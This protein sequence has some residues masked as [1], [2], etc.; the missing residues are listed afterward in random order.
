VAAMA[1][2]A[3]VD[4]KQ[5]GEEVLR[6]GVF[7]WGRKIVKKWLGGGRCILK[8]RRQCGAVGGRSKCGH[9]LGG[10]WG[11]GSGTAVGR[12]R[13]EADMRRWA[14]RSGVSRGGEGG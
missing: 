4:E 6:R 3:W 2:V 8:G 1:P 9:A 10:A 14:V 13:P 12:Q 5:G 7:T 11:G